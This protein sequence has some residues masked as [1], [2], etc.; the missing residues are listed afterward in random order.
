MWQGIVWACSLVGWSCASL[1]DMAAIQT[2]YEQE[3]AAGSKLHDKDLKVLKA[4]CHDEGKRPFLCEVM[5]ISTTDPSERLLFDVVA[6]SRRGDGWE[7]KSGLCKGQ[8]T[9]ISSQ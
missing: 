6:V 2:A 4:N 9:G 3:A 1:P 8:R 7:L 5:F